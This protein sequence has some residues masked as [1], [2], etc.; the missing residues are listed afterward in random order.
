MYKREQIDET[1]Y[2]CESNI[3]A[4]DKIPDDSYPY[5]VVIINEHLNVD[6]LAHIVNET[7]SKKWT[8]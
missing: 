7:L 5:G 4:Y 1:T 8:N 2:D 6:E 3:A